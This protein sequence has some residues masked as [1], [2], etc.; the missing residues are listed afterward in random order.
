MLAVQ[1]PIIPVVGDL[2]R[3]HPGTISL[4]QGV[5]HYGPPPEAIAGIQKFLATPHHH[6]YQA[7]QGLPELLD[8]IRSKLAR[9]NGIAMCDDQ[10]V[11]VTAGGNMAFLNAVTAIADPGDEII[12]QR[13]FYFNHEMAITMVNAVPVSVDTDGQYQLRPDAI[14]EAITDRTRAVVTI[15]PNNPTGAVYSEAALRQVNEL[16]RRHGIYHICDE[17]YEY[18]TYPR[19]GQSEPVP[20]FAA[21]SIP[22]ADQHTISIFSLSKSYGFASWRMGYMV[23]PEHLET[24]IKKIQDTN[25]ICPPVICQHAAVGALESEMRQDNERTAH[26]H[27]LTEVH[28]MV[29]H[30]LEQ[31]GDAVDVPPAE[32]AFYYLMKL[33]TRQ[34]DMAIVEHLIADHG[35]AVIP[36]QTFG[37]DDACCLRI[38]YGALEK[39]TV[40]EGIGRLVRG[41]KAIIRP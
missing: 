14:A 15:S 12:V 37:I 7:V 27:A 26:L 19:D 2:I 22:G 1:S 13:P 28:H 32:G 18:F 23:I 38:A 29:H 6:K 34:H 39:D 9:D 31:L 4:G 20:H 21:G 40:A 25:L 8:A 41:L 16:C 24:A 30:K 11:I 36:G 3:Q 5:V 35:V 10:R 17:A 33:N